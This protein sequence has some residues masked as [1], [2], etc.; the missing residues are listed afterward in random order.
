MA[1]QAG[2]MALNSWGVV[3]TL[4]AQTG[5]VVT[6]AKSKANI[7]TRLI[8]YLDL[9]Y[10][11]RTTADHETRVTSDGFVYKQKNSSPRFPAR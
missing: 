2:S 3:C 10:G 9:G 11:L 8:A 5:A 1:W 6:A 7:L 4:F